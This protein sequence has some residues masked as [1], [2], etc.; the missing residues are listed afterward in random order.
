MDLA[1]LSVELGTAPWSAAAA[2]GRSTAGLVSGAPSCTP[3]AQLLPNPG[4]KIGPGSTEAMVVLKASL[5]ALFFGSP[6]RLW[7]SPVVPEQLSLGVAM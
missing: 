6:S 4:P 7:F 3:E 2:T 1:G 5:L